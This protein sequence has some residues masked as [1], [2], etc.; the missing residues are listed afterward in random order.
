MNI[1]V[2]II[3]FVII[4]VTLITIIIIIIIVTIRHGLHELANH[5]CT[6]T[7]RTITISHPALE[8]S[9]ISQRNSRFKPP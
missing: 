5:P 7:A 2:V 8:A 6:T 1:I 9:S 3:I 4:V